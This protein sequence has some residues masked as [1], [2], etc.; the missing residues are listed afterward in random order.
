M[1]DSIVI[2]GMVI[3]VF[4]VGEYDKVLTILTQ[5]RGKISAFARGARKM[6]NKF[7]AVS[8]LF[9]FGQFQIYPGRNS[10][11]IAEANITYY[12]DELHQDLEAAYYGMYFLE[13][14]DY[15]TRENN[16]ES[17]MLKLLFQSLR[18]L[19]HPK[20][21]CDFVRAVFECKAMVVNGEFPGIPKTMQVSETTRYAIEHISFTA[22]EKLY[23]F[24][25]SKESLEELKRVC[26]VNCSRIWNH[27]FKSLTVLNDFVVEKQN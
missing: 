26:E 24:A 1:Q 17:E 14:T 9:C 21:D 2:T 3:K 11:T 22:S 10:Y 15:Y 5:E 6:H 20:F 13:I 7:M 19:L 16:E 25:L 12:F 27:T 8:N 18:A 23:S 4:P